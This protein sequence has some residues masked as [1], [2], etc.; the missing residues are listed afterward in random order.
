MRSETDSRFR[1]KKTYPHWL[2]VT[3]L[4]ISLA[5]VASGLWVRAIGLAARNASV[6]PE[7]L[8]PW[9][10]GEPGFTSL[11]GTKAI[12]DTA[13]VYL[14]VVNRNNKQY[15]TGAIGNASVL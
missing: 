4:A 8:Q 6:A 7:P 2:G 11:F 13:S 12:S 15:Q 5:L 10:A 3:I 14:P 1:R 9:S